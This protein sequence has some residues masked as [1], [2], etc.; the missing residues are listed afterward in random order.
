MTF[1]LLFPFFLLLPEPVFR[2]R[3]FLGFLAGFPLCFLFLTQSS[4]SLLCLCSNALP[5][6]LP[7]YFPLQTLRIFPLAE[8]QTSV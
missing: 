2:L 6:R 7:A 1:V 3:C 8:L 5:A 4:Q